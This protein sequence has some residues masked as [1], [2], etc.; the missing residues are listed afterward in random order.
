MIFVVV[1]LDRGYQY[2]SFAKRI[3]WKGFIE[4]ELYQNYSNSHVWIWM[5]LTISKVQFY[6]RIVFYTFLGIHRHIICN[7]WINRTIDMIF[8]SFKLFLFIKSNSNSGL[9]EGCHVLCSDWPV[10]LRVDHGLQPSD[11]SGSERPR[12]DGTVSVFKTKQIHWIWI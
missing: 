3:N 6:Y 9:T 11:Q 2:D 4:F 7:F 5:F 10:P 8:Q 1:L 12:S